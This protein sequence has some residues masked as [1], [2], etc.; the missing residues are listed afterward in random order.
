MKVRLTKITGDSNK[1]DFYSEGF[2]CDG[3]VFT[4]K[5]GDNISMTHTS[6]SSEEDWEGDVYFYTPIDKVLRL[7]WGFI[8]RCGT[9]IWSIKELNF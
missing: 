8:I 1:G 3:Y 9:E 6:A 5:I 7:S 2:W 4:P